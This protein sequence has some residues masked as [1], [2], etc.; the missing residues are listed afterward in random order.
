MVNIGAVDTLAPASG[1]WSTFV[2][3]LV[4]LIIIAF[5]FAV[6][7]ITY[8]V[9]G[10]KQDGVFSKIGEFKTKA[11]HFG[12]M[13]RRNNNDSDEW[14]YREHDAYERLT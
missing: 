4:S 11:Q 3:F 10:R 5:I 9:Y 7:F 12:G 14:G 8:M 2:R 1:F 13:F 6:A